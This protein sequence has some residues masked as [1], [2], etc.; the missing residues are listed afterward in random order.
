MLCLEIGKLQ[1][2]LE[3]FETSAN[4]MRKNMQEKMNEGVVEMKGDGGGGESEKDA[5]EKI[6]CDTVAFRTVIEKFE[7]KLKREK[8]IRDLQK[9][10]MNIMRTLRTFESATSG[11]TTNNN[12]ED[13]DATSVCSMRSGFSY[14]SVDTCGTSLR[15]VA[16][17][18]KRA[19]AIAVELMKTLK[20]RDGLQEEVQ[21]LDR[22]A[23]NIQEIINGLA[24]KSFEKCEQINIYKC[25]R[26]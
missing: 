3:N 6:E 4:A 17:L 12:N 23:K 9:A 22:D 11:E 16:R 18:E 7:K 26:A 14:T 1:K 25:K 8:E 10:K 19:K 15:S 13:D 2:E 20:D 21:I 24:K 5:F